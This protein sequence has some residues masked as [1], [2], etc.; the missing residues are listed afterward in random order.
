MPGKHPCLKLSPTLAAEAV[1]CSFHVV[2]H[3]HYSKFVISSNIMPSFCTLSLSRFVLLHRNTVLKHN[4]GSHDPHHS[5]NL[6][7]C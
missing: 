6:A 4:E 3:T 1:L 5:L 7:C 2:F